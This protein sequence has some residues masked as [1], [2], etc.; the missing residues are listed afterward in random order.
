[1][2]IYRPIL[3]AVEQAVEHG[4]RDAAEHVLEESNRRAPKDD[5]DLVDS[6]SVSVTDLQAR[7]HYKSFYA[8][9]QHERLDYAHDDGEAKFL[10][11][12]AEAEMGAALQVM[13]ARIRG[14]L[15]G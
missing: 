13:G 4:M 1:M 5:G 8:A 12:A 6:S 2:K 14:E 15:G 3:S 11:N 10:E 7:I 9:W